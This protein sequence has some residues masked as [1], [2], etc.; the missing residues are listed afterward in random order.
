MAYTIINTIVVMREKPVITAN[1]NDIGFE[2][3]FD[4]GD[5]L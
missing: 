5:L 2:N 3:I 4:G 1:N